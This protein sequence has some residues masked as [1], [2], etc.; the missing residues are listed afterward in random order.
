MGRMRPRGAWADESGP[1]PFRTTVM[2]GPD[3]GIH[4]VP[5]GARAEA[6]DGRVKPGHDDFRRRMGRMRPRGAWADESG[7]LPSAPPSC[8]DLIRASTG[9]RREHERR[10]VDGRVKPGHDDFRGRM[11]RMRPRG[12]WAGESGPAPFRTTVMP[13]L[14]PAST[15]CRRVRQPRAV[16]GRVK[17]GH[18]DL[19]GARGGRGA[20]PPVTTVMPGHDDVGRARDEEGRRPKEPPSCPDLIRASTGFRRV[21][22]LRAGMER[23]SRPSTQ[24]RHAPAS[25]SHPSACRH[26]AKALSPER[27]SRDRA[28]AR[29]PDPPGLEPR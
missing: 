1:A 27:G 18:D 4:G 17:P 19:K 28:R 11:G 10:A 3:P 21:H 14:D 15:E 16:D 8:P 29:S 20:A 9:F 2:P 7:P 23:S 5:P 12:A 13:G 24:D 25:P 26:V 6:V 22:R